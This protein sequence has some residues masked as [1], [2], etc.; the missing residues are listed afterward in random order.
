MDERDLTVVETT[1]AVPEVSSDDR[2]E[3]QKIA[4]AMKTALIAAGMI[5]LS[6]FLTGVGSALKDYC[7]KK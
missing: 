4:E 2:F 3:L 6:G 7:L 5:A 1:A